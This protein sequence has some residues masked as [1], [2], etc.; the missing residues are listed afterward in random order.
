MSSWFPKLE[1]VS[2]VAFR[3]GLRCL[4]GGPKGLE[5]RVIRGLP[6]VFGTGEEC[7]RVIWGAEREEE[8]DRERA[9]PL[10]KGD[11]VRGR[12][13][14]VAERLAKGDGARGEF[15]AVARGGVSGR[16]PV[17]SVGRGGRALRGASS[18]SRVGGGSIMGGSVTR[19]TMIVVVCWRG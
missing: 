18:T 13:G 19:G 15:E 16:K 6:V 12:I 11:R 9:W 2:S 4:S 1:N 3:I 10:A 8:D 14:G 5:G 7:A 17:R